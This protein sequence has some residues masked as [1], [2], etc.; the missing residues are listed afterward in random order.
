MEKKRNQLFRLIGPA[1]LVM[2]L[3][4]CGG[5]GGGGGDIS[6]GGITGSSGL[7]LSITDAPVVDADISAVWV[8]FTQVIL[9]PANG[10]GDIVYDVSDDTDP[11]DIKPYRDIEL[12]SLVGGKTMLLGEIPLDA[13]KYSWIRLVIDPAN[14]H[15]IET[16]GGDYLMDCPSC[17]QSGLKLNR[18]FTIE[19]NGW[20][21]FTIDF[22]L[23]KSITLRQPNKSPRA[24]YDYKLRPT[25]RILETELASSYIYGDVTDL[26]S[27]KTNPAFPDG[28]WVYVYNG[29]M[30]TIV[31]DDICLNADPAVCKPA[32]RPSLE[33][34]VVFDSSDGSYSY[35][36]GYIY[37]GTYTLALVCESDDPDVDE[38]LLFISETQVLAAAVPEGAQQDLDL[39]DAAQLSLHKTLLD[40]ADEDTS[41]SVTPGDTLTYQF[42]ASNTG[43]IPLTNV[44]ISDPM[45][46]L[47]GL[48]CDIALPASLAPAEAVTCTAAYVVQQTDTVIS[49]TATAD[50]DQTAAV[51]SSL[52]VAVD[53]P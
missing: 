46:G 38:D 42:V 30:A 13:G 34:P 31:P 6:G 2:L 14:T 51:S 17:T 11:N 1:C 28:C 40:N 50:S 7:S 47:G 19:A 52:D 53:V 33:T 12:K 26:R 15:I 41:A 39:V 36:T 44:V 8:R 32:D 4:A 35:N 23:R 48:G 3:S 43:N 18:S 10:S 27:D 37:P 29:D 22:D 21:N 16:G 25:L 24:D 49:N 9:H 20:I 45:A 5:G